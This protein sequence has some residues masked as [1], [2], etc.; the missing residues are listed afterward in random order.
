MPWESYY[1]R[2]AKYNGVL[3]YSHCQIPLADKTLIFKYCESPEK[4]SH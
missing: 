4:R 1:Y 2:N 3:T